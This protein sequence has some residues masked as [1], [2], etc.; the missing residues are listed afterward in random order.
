MAKQSTATATPV[1]LTRPE[2]QSR[3]FAEAL[4]LRFGDRLRCVVAP[5]MAPIFLSPHLPEGHFDA[6]IFTSATAVNAARMLG[7]PLPTR[8]WCVGARTA[9]AAQAAEFN[10]SSANGDAD[11]LVAAI[12]SD[13]PKGRLLHLRGQDSRG[14]VAERLTA[15]GITTI[16]AIFYRQ[17]PQPLTPEAIAL[18]Q[19]PAPLILPIFSPGSAAVLAAALPT[20]TLA[21]L[22]IA[23]ISAAVAEAAASIPH[24]ALVTARNPD[25]D[26]M[27][28]GVGTLLAANPLP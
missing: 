19:D 6:V 3:A 12:L 10:A 14:N 1:L 7:T 15:H 26:G 23:A 2:A 20:T 11:D 16:S 17:E 25:A 24:V 22:H 21:R 8:A 9:E 28:N 27:L 18:L 4:V 5:T 13:P